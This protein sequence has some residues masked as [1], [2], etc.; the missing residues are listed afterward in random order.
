MTAR[1]ASNLE[2][3]ISRILVGTQSGWAWALPGIRPSKAA[4]QGVAQSHL[5]A[6]MP[7]NARASV[8]AFDL[9]EIRSVN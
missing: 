6:D 8:R 7:A 9:D 3:R 5:D 1:V 4:P 2:G